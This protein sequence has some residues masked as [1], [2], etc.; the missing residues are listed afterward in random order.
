MTSS[1]VTCEYV[2]SQLFVVGGGLRNGTRP[3]D[4]ENKLNDIG[5]S[6]T[7][8]D[9]K[10]GKLFTPLTPGLSTSRDGN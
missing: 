4:N 1:D 9:N 10:R 3:R 8:R 5:V 2:S 7:D 6:S